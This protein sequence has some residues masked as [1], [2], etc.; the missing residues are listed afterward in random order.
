MYALYRDI[1]VPFYYPFD[2]YF[3]LTWLFYMVDMVTFH[4]GMVSCVPGSESLTFMLLM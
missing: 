1:H 4:I 2:D 3:S